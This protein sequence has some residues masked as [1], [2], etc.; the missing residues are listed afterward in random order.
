MTPIPYSHTQTFMM[1]YELLIVCIDLCLSFLYCY[2]N[3]YCKN[4]IVLFVFGCSKSKCSHWL[5]FSFCINV[6]S[7]SRWYFL[8]SYQ[9]SVNW[10]SGKLN[11]SFREKLTIEYEG[12]HYNF[13]SDGVV[14]TFSRPDSVKKFN[15]LN[16]CSG[17][18][19]HAEFTSWLN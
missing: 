5:M 7:P 8:I 4:L 13:F 17:V 11:F 3:Q 19:Y 12:E 10:I 2:P 1:L 14:L 6:I 15:V 18:I 16:M 9:S